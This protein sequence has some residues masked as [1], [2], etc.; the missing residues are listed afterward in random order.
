[1]TRDCWRSSNYWC[2][3]NYHEPGSERDRVML[4]VRAAV[5][6]RMQCEWSQDDSNLTWVPIGDPRLLLV[7]T[8]YGEADHLRGGFP[9]AVPRR[10]L[11]EATACC[12]LGSVGAVA[13][14]A[15]NGSVCVRTS[16]DTRSLS[17]A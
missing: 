13:R 5:A 15:P 11:E 8:G 6:W 17:S 7:R 9:R 10:V 4:A 1:M 14:P 3:P 2:C 16:S 12:T